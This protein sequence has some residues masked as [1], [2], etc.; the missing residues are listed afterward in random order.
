MK[1]QTKPKLYKMIVLQFPNALK[2]VARRCKIGHEK[3]PELDH[4]YKG[5]SKLPVDE[6]E[7]AIIRHIM[8]DGE[9]DEIG[10]WGAVAWNALAILELKIQNE[11]N[12]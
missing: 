11:N 3:Y 7:D 10:H 4:D 9:E 8:Q 6:Y 2:E 12:K 5:F 1:D